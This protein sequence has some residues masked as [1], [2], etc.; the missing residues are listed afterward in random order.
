[1]IQRYE[2]YNANLEQRSDG[3]IVFYADHLADKEAAVEEEE[4]EIEIRRKVMADIVR[5]L[6]H[7][8]GGLSH[9]DILPVLKAKLEQITGLE[10]TASEQDNCILHFQARVAALKAEI[11]QLKFGREPLPCPRADK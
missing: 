4:E 7:G 9:E 6:G 8:P 5:V 10:K 3:R 1:M 11:E 2:Y